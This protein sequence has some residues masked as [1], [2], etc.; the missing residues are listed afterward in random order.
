MRGNTDDNHT[1]MGHIVIHS[2]SPHSVSV[3]TADISHTDDN[4]TDKATFP[5]KHTHTHIKNV[6][7]K[8]V[9]FVQKADR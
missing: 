9:Y 2:D 4:H 5:T 8:K 3:I 6:E 7:K 1:D